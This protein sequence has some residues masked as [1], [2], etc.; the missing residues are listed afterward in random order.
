MRTTLSILILAALIRSLEPLSSLAANNIRDDPR[1]APLDTRLNK[2]YS[3][4]RSKL[5]SVRKEELKQLKLD[6]LNQREKL[7]NN[8]DTYFGLTQK[9]IATLEEM[10]DEP[11][12]D[13]GHI[14]PK[15]NANNTAPGSAV[16]GTSPDGKYQLRRGK[17]LVIGGSGTTP[18][19]LESNLD[20]SPGRDVKEI[21]WSPA[22]GKVLVTVASDKGTNQIQIA[23][24]RGTVWKADFPPGT[25]NEPAH[26]LGDRQKALR[27][28]S[29]D[30]F[31]MSD[32]VILNSRELNSREPLPAVT[33]RVQITGTAAR[34]L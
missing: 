30:V 11:S 33:Y 31:E 27:W 25:G 9:Q 7:V 18:A 17:E 24:L 10:R 21:L 1:Y 5:S 15:G 12:T 3:A 6:F 19:T 28:I 16:V 8:P 13:A 34:K 22:G 23:W 20:I 14:A 26:Y 29:D 4:V 32:V 2:V